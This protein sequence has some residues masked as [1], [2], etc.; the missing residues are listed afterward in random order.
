LQGKGWV[1]AK[2]L[3]PGNAVAAEQGD[4]LI[5]SIK[6]VN[7]SVRVYNFSVANTQTY[8]VSKNKLW[9]HNANTDCDIVGRDLTSRVESVDPTKGDKVQMPTNPSV[10]AATLA[11]YA[12]LNSHGIPC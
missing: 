3:I 5:R 10:N 2:D 6:K 7:E 11:T 4:I 9:V 12:K 1:E 8:F